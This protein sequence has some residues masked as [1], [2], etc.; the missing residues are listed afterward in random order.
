MVKPKIPQLEVERVQALAGTHAS[1]IAQAQGYDPAVMR[2]LAQ[3]G[4]STRIGDLELLPLGLQ[5]QLCLN[6]HAQ[7]FPEADPADLAQGM[8]RLCRFALMFSAPD[9]AFEIL[10]QSDITAEEKRASLDR[11]AFAVAG[12]FRDDAAIEALSAHI[13]VQMGL[14]EDACPTLPEPPKK[15]AWMPPARSRRKKR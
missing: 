11:A 12:H 3:Y 14:L 13:A 10:T 7:L 9:A 4:K 15:K 1:Q 5:V 8:K 2:A 6:E